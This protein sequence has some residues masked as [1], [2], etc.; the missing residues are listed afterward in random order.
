MKN[1]K[2]VAYPSGPQQAQQALALLYAKVAGRPGTGS[3]PA[4]SPSPTTQCSGMWSGNLSRVSLNTSLQLVSQYLVW[5][6]ALFIQSIYEPPRDKTNKM[7]C[8]P[9]E[10]SDQPRHPPS[11]IR[12]FAVLS[13]GSWPKLSS[14][15][16]QRLW[17]DW[18]DA[19]ADLSLCWAHMPFCSFCHEAAQLPFLCCHPFS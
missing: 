16:Q 2:N 13:M 11:L 10:D 7:T 1:I 9:S 3:Y 8:A 12:V 19:Q 17:S 14:C 4:P 6:A 5:L 18:A 15:G